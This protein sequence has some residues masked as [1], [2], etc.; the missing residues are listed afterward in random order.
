MPGKLCAGNI[1]HAYILNARAYCEGVQSAKSA[2]TRD[3]NPHDETENPVAYNDWDRGWVSAGGES[4]C[5]A[6]ADDN[7][8]D[9]LSFDDATDWTLLDSTSGGGS[10]VEDSTTSRTDGE[11]VKFTVDVDATG[12]NSAQMWQFSAFDIDLSTDK[13]IGFWVYC[14]DQDRVDRNRWQSRITDSTSGFAAYMRYNDS[15]IAAYPGW[16][17][18]ET[19][20]SEWESI[21]GGSWG[22]NM[23]SLSFVIVA[24]SSRQQIFRID[25]MVLDHKARPYVVFTFDDTKDSQYD[26]AWKDATHGAEGKGV[27]LTLYAI[28]SLLG[29]ASYMSEAELTEMYDAGCAV[30]LHDVDPWDD[31]GAPSGLTDHIR[32]LRDEY[33]QWPRDLDHASYPQGRYG[34]DPDALDEPFDVFDGLEVAGVKTCRTVEKIVQPVSPHGMPHQMNVHGINLNQDL[35]LA[36]AKAYIDQAILRGH[37]CVFYGHD[38]GATQGTD[39]WITSDWGELLDYAISKQN[40]DGLAIVTIPE[41]FNA[42]GK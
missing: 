3:S 10:T 26:L 2:E 18:I 19:H 32:S 25:Q 21:G 15:T 14:D 35:S 5:S 37:T 40:S 8:S 24:R 1:D 30:C 31:K 28:P 12:S 39:Q 41:W 4:C 13:N 42:V 7:S 29:G 9:I 33:S 22:A 20:S 6:K 38:L 34:H 27:P 11:S 16:N 17:W 23:R 36:E